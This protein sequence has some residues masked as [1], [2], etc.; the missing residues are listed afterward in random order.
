VS[1]VWVAVFIVGLAAAAHQGWAA[2]VFTLVGD[3]FPK[4]AVGTV[5]GF[6]GMAGAVGGMFIAKLTGFLLQ[7]TGSYF[8]VFVI[9]GTAY[10]AAL[11][12]VQLIVPRLDPVRLAAAP[13]LDA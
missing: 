8:V 7:T 9:A 3:M 10:L 1:S 13:T 4:Q 6:G 11:A 12:I 5:V 2:N